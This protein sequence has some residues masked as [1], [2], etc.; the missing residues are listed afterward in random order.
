M[1]NGTGSEPQYFIYFPQTNNFVSELFVAGYQKF[2]EG[3]MLGLTNATQEVKGIVNQYGATGL[4]MDGHSRGTMTVD[5]AYSSLLNDGDAGAYPNLRT[6]MAGPAANVNNADAKL[7]QLQGRDA[8]LVTAPMSPEGSIYRPTTEQE[9]SDM[10][11]QYQNHKSDFVGNI[12]GGNEPTG[13]NNSAG[14][15][16]TDEWKNMFGGPATVHS[17]YGSG[18]PKCDEKNYWKDSSITN[19]RGFEIPEWKPVVQPNDNQQITNK[20]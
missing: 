14:A 8:I 11:I 18:N 13:G 6:N 2:L 5:N 10:S 4:Q 1:Q 3:D 20:D 12:I 9:K 7:A 19:I 15:S 16:K 17:C